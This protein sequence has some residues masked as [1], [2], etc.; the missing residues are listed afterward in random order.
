MK[1]LTS[2]ILRY[3]SGSPPNGHTC[4]PTAPLTAAFTKPYFAQLKYKFCTFTFCKWPA[5]VTDSDFVTNSYGE[6]W[7]SS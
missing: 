2:R 5:P 7:D 6:S 4:K 3:Y 1:G